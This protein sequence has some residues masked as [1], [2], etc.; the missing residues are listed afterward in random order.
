MQVLAY[1]C[2][3][4]VD[5]TGRCDYSAAVQTAFRDDFDDRRDRMAE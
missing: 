4:V 3:H 5:Q 1:F 2:L